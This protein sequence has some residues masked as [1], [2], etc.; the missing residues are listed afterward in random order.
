MLKSKIDLKIPLFIIWPFGAFLASLRNIN[1]KSSQFIYIL[2]TTLFG[3][4][5]SFTFQSADSYKVAWVFKN[6]NHN[7]ISLTLQN[8]LDGK[9]TDIYK[10]LMYNLIEI[11]T[12]NPKVLFAALGFVFGIF[13]Y[14][15]LKLL[16][17]IKGLERSLYAFIIVLIFFS[18]NSIVNINGARFWT[19][20][21]ICFCSIVNLM[22]YNKKIWYLGLFSTI[23]F[24]FSFLFIV[25][26]IILFKV[27][28]KPL[29]DNKKTPSWIL[30]IFTFTFFFSFL[31]ESNIININALAQLLPSSIAR[32]VELYNSIEILEKLEESNATI[33]HT[34]TRFFNYLIRIYIFILILKVSRILKRLKDKN[35]VLQNL[36]SFILLFFS[37]TFML[38]LFPSG[39]RFLTIS[40]QLFFYFFLR[41]Y[42]EYKPTILNKYILGLIPVFSFTISFSV[43]FLAIS[44]TSG[45]LW[46]GN[47]FWIIYEGIG[48]KL[49]AV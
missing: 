21:I 13:S 1:S 29:F 48:F 8:Y 10:P 37:V 32:K 31:L 36:F 41:F 42:L 34:I 9:I 18:L 3:Y 26:F 16:L 46:F 45:T 17:Q 7:T 49:P 23:L 2:F 11:F 47:V 4:S 39:G 40:L 19:A 27:F 43:F 15:S 12:D 38:S 14:K 6:Y 33:F 24:H 20:A 25:P 30:F 5:F 44:L 35:S 28:K 22:V